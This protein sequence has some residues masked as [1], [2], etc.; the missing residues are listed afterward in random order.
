MRLPFVEA[1]L[2]DDPLSPRVRF[3]IRVR[4][5]LSESVVSETYPASA[6][7]IA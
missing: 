6:R 2:R 7:R 1:V 5:R 4:A 3:W